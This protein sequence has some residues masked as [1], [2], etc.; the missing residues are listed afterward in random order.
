MPHSPGT[1]NTPGTGHR[2][3]A[4]RG[5]PQQITAGRVTALLVLAPA[6]GMFF[7]GMVFA[8]LC[9]GG[10]SLAAVRV[11]PAGL[12]WVLPLAP[13]AIWTVCVGRELFDA[14]GSR[15]GQAVA[16]A[17]GMIE[18]FPAMAVT[19]AATAAVALLRRVARRRSARA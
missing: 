5:R 2:A 7:G 13:V 10:A 19:L 14:S 9:A 18:A 8:V 15:S 1:R 11:R 3:P 12:W 17:R 6:V 16:V 4:R